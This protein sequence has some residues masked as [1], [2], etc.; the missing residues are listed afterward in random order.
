MRR[1]SLRSLLIALNVGLVTGALVAVVTAS[2]IDLRRLAN[3]QALAQA[4]LAAAAAR[5]A[6]RLAGEDLVDASRQAVERPGLR[7]L[8]ANQDRQGLRTFL[9]RARAASGYSGCA[10]VRGG[11]ILAASPRDLPWDNVVTSMAGTPATGWFLGPR[12]GNVPFL[13]AGTTPVEKP[14]PAPAGPAAGEAPA[15]PETIMIFTR[16]ADREFERSLT[17]QVGLETHVL[18]WREISEEASDQSSLRQRALEEGRPIAARLDAAGAFLALEPVA[19]RGGAPEAL[20]ETAL[21]IGEIDAAAKG[22]FRSVLAV[23]II[24]GGAA[25]LLGAIVARRLTRPIQDL[26]RASARIGRGDLTTPIPRPTGAAELGELAGAMEEMR[27]RLLELTAESR[28]R[29]KDAEAILGGISEGVY[30]VDRERRVRFL[31]RQTAELLGIDPK[32]AIG[33]FC[34]DVLNPQGPDGIRPCEDNCPILDARFRGGAR[35]TERLLLR[36]GTT[37]TVVINSAPPGLPEEE[38][39]GGV[40]PG[41]PGPGRQFQLIRDETEIEATRRLR[42]AVLANITHEFRTPLSA[43][44]ASLELLRERMPENASPE[45]LEL[46]SSLERGALRLTQLIDNLLESVRLDAGHSDIRRQPLAL[47]EVVEE[48]AQATA[49]LLDLRGQRLEV[50]LP[51][52]LPP[53]QGDAP[54]LVQVF[55]NLIANANKFAPTGTVIKVGGQVDRTS[56]TL[57]VEDQGPGFPA[58]DGVLLFEPFTRS[59]GEEPEQSGMGL[60][61]YIVKS[62]VERHGG[63]V[64]ARPAKGHGARLSLTLPLD[65]PARAAQA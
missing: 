13:I 59:P 29:R 56:V 61:L 48:A 20:V 23:G 22:L 45:T 12:V 34:G 4:R 54:R 41:T 2:A 36:N 24:A 44:L 10:L 51:Y 46:L 63:H 49:P 55:V 53:L 60:G 15:P 58:E 62:I 43:Q 52:P 5:Q 17:A 50:D 42:D 21:P 7:T 32:E 27:G 37:L 47:D 30:A 9:D 57:W 39:E 31:N 26:T 18:G 33:R 35:A 8:L 25:G 14:E 38:G 11:E 28:R 16:L 19:T 40:G 64:E 6:L 65:G 3:D 1:L